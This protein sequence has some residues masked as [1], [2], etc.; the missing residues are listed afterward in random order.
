MET[1]WELDIPAILDKIND[2][3][4]FNYSKMLN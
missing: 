3:R 1:N 4:Y 2:C